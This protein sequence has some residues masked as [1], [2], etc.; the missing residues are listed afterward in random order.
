MK[1]FY[2]SSGL[3]YK[4]GWATT[5]PRQSDMLGMQATPS[6]LFNSPKFREL[7][8]KLENDE[9]PK[10]CHLCKESEEIGHPSMRQ[11]YEWVDNNLR[12][13]ELRFSNACN[14]ACLHCS[15]VVRCFERSPLRTPEADEQKLQPRKA[16]QS[17]VHAFFHKK[18]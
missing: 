13:V 11:D 18:T 17:N 5:C 4:N 1:C 15:E 16:R 8:E 2:A 3:N 9:W 6:I 14:M 7:R 10:G 12:H